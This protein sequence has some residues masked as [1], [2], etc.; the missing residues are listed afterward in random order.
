MNRVPARAHGW[1]ERPGSPQGSAASVSFGPDEGCRGS[2]CRPRAISSPPSP[3]PTPSAVAT[4]AGRDSSP[5][6]QE[7]FTLDGAEASLTGR[8]ESAGTPPPDSVKR[9]CPP[10]NNALT[11]CKQCWTIRLHR[12]DTIQSRTRHVGSWKSAPKTEL[13]GF[14]PS[15]TSPRENSRWNTESPLQPCSQASRSARTVLWP[16]AIPP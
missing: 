7:R 10:R 5:L 8:G 11:R 1:R 9:S 4:A 3:A 16:R 13:Y 6:K 12:Q 15:R 2:F 14:G